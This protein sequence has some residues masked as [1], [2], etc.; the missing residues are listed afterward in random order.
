MGEHSLLGLR[1]RERE[2]AAPGGP[3]RGTGET[4]GQ[5]DAFLPPHQ[6]Q[7]RISRKPHL[8]DQR[9][10]HPLKNQ[11]GRCPFLRKDRCPRYWALPTPPLGR[12]AV[13]FPGLL[14]IRVSQSTAP[15]PLHSER[16]WSR[17]KNPPSLCREPAHPGLQEPSQERDSPWL[18]SCPRTLKKVF[19]KHSSI[20]FSKYGVKRTKAMCAGQRRG[21]SILIAPPR[22][23]S[24]QTPTQPAGKAVRTHSRGDGF[25]RFLSQNGGAS[26]TPPPREPI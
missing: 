10:G 4:R 16:Q 11:R 12:T 5:P 22:H 18:T 7:K 6:P 14:N 19:G 2:L 3:G 9:L 15:F 24:P 23:D 21:V 1:N 25:S 26:E 17:P 13:W 20:P 8:V